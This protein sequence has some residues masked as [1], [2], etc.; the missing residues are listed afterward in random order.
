MRLTPLSSLAAA[1]ALSWASTSLATPFNPNH[2]DFGH[3]M[4]GPQ[5]AASSAP[6]GVE[7]AHPHPHP[8]RLADK[9]R[10]LG[11]SNTI[12]MTDHSPL[13]PAFASGK[14]NELLTHAEYLD[15]NT[16]AGLAPA[17]YVETAAPVDDVHPLIF[18][19]SGYRKM[20]E[21]ANGN[22][23]SWLVDRTTDPAVVTDADEDAG[24]DGGTHFH[25]KL[26]SVVP[27]NL[28]D[29]DLTGGLDVG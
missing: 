2:P 22:R 15:P 3:F 13:V 6:V 21:E 5:L 11:T 28:S 17:P 20:L 27:P 25:K 16:A 19:H 10:L 18:R 29:L 12:A 23:R 14:K 1:T 7:F 26:S 9:R 24:A 8:H 4:R